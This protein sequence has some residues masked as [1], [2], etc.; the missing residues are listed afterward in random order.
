MWQSQ[1]F[2][3]VEGGDVDGDEVWA[4]KEKDGYWDR[5][6]RSDWKGVQEVFET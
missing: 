6:A 2:E 4:L 5:R 1:F 3:K